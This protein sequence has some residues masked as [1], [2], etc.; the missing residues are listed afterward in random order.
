METRES[1]TDP[2]EP[3]EAR[4]MTVLYWIIGLP[5]IVAVMVALFHNPRNVPTYWRCSANH[6]HQTPE[7]ARRCSAAQRRG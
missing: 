6:R 2:A 5:I 7:A 4:V 3:K 1:E